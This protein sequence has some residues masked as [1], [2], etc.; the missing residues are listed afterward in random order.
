M[1]DSL[2]TIN[3]RE[4][5][6]YKS[7]KK[8][9]R[10]NKKRRNI[11]SDGEE[12]RIENR[13][14]EATGSEAS[15]DEEGRVREEKMAQDESQEQR[16][17]IGITIKLINRETGRVSLDLVCKAIGSLTTAAGRIGSRISPMSPQPSLR[18]GGRSRCIALVVAVQS[19][20]GSG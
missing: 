2:K 14:R 9:V 16:E 15:E 19:S 7:N 10:G 18:T 8:Q 17:E 12:G 4:R 1:R 13:S 5:S 6:R 11:S 3:K 20:Y